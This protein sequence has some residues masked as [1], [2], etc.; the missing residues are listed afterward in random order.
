MSE[1]IVGS[2][3]GVPH[4]KGGARI[5]WMEVVDERG[6][7]VKVKSPTKAQ[8]AGKARW[9]DRRTLKLKR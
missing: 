2:I 1:S 3:V 9:V 7:F 4:L 5:W 8:A 6:N